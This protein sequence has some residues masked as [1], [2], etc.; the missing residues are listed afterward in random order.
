[1]VKG[2]RMKRVFVLFWVTGA[3]GWSQVGTAQ[4]PYVLDGTPTG[5]EEEIRWRVNRGRFDTASENQIRSTSYTDVPASTGPLAPNQSLALASRHQSE[6][7]AKHNIFQH[8]TVTNSA[9]YNWITQPNPWD[10]MTAEGYSWNSAGEN[11]AAG[12]S[13]SEAVYVGWWNSRGHRENMFNSGFREIG[14]GYFYWAASS[15]HAYYT[16]DLGSSG[17]TR[18]FTDTLFN[19]ANGNGT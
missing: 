1:M 4:T 6:D 13:G 12:Y 18:F 10:R 9:Y 17:S 2:Q 15:F 5:A 14:C 8:T 3:L 7:M 16:M 11:I 19:D